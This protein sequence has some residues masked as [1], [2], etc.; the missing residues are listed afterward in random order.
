MGLKNKIGVNNLA[1]IEDILLK[2]NQV[3]IEQK[4]KPVEKDKFERCAKVLKISRYAE[5]K[6]SGKQIHALL[7]ESNKVLKVS[8]LQV[9]RHRADRYSNAESS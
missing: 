8:N 5:I 2:W 7:E 4:A 9:P 1:A 6:D 3:F